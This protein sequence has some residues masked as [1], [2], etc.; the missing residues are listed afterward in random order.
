MERLLAWIR[1][2]PQFAAVGFVLVVL[3]IVMTVLG[4]SMQRAGLSLRPLIWFLGFFAIVGGPQAVMHLLDG[5]LQPRATAPDG[6]RAQPATAPETAGP[7]TASRAL[8]PV[9]WPVVF[10]PD[11]DP[12]LIVDAKLGL[13]PVLGDATEARI[14]YHARGDSALAARFDSAAAALT[15]Q[16]KYGT[17]FAFAQ[18]SGSDADGWTAR[19][20]QGQG[21]WVHVVAAGPELYAWTS[22]TRETVLA[23]RARALGPISAA[24]AQAAPAGKGEAPEL[25]SLRLTRRTGL[26]VAIVGLNLI[27]AVLWFFK[28]S[29][30]SA[31]I[32]GAAVALPADVSTLRTSL[33][34]LNRPAVPTEVTT[35]PDGALEVSWRYGDARWF[36]LMRVHRLKRAHRLVLI[37]D[38]ARRT[39]RVREYMSAF[40]ASASPGTLRL[41][42]KAVTGIQFFAF[43]KTRVLGAQLGSDGRPTGELS[44]GYTFNLQELKAPLIEAVT[45]A[46]WRW[47][48]LTWN[49]PESL[50]WLTE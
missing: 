4:I 25:F 5:Y 27:A 40:D 3:T 26:M 7:A 44:Q 48:P 23:A 16:D 13:A 8:S 39:V 45:Q 43:E 9:P 30:W 32:D 41:E 38:E 47:Q 10:G 18:A 42:W 2:H 19:R 20:H 36:D 6:T 15:A 1:D 46:G 33:L 24:V 35:R 29:A 28:G 11:A 49:A 22:A 37:F 34:G 17:F 21:E 50:R 31:R 14:S 12:T